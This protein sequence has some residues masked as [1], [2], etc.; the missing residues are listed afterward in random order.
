VAHQDLT[1]K[2]IGLTAEQAFA[3]ATALREQG[4]LSEAERIYRAVLRLD[5]D[6]FESLHALGIICIQ[7]DVPQD[8]LPLIERALLLH[9]NS[10]EAHNN[11]GIALAK[12]GRNEEAVAQYDRAVALAP[13]FAAAHSNAANALAASGR[14]EEAVA[15]FATALGLAPDRSDTHNDLGVALATLGRH[16]EA[17]AH[18]EQAAA[19]QPDF[20]AAHNNLGNALVELDRS[21]EAIAP[22]E[23]ALVIQPDFAQAELNL[24]NALAA[25]HRHDAAVDHYRKAL[26]LEPEL[27]AAHC[28][29]GSSLH[30]SNR[31]QQA[32]MSYERARELDL[33]SAAASHGVGLVLQTLGRLEQSRRALE[34]A[35]EL[36]P[37]MPAY[38]RALA[39]TRVF[40]AGDPQLA[41][42]E[43]LAANLSALP[44]TQQ[45]ELHF[46]LGKA[47]EDLG[48]HE[49]AFRHLLDGNAM[50][51]RREEY[52][53]DATLALWRR[54]ETVFTADLLQRNAGS[55]DPSDAPV[56][57]LGMPRS[58]STLIEQV[59]ASHPRVF[60]AGELR[61]MG[62]AAKAFR[63][64][65][66][67]AYFPEVAASITSEQLRQFGARYVEQIR[68]HAPA[69]DR[70][71]DKMPPNFRFIGLIRLALPNARIIHTQRDPLD[72]CLSCFSRLFGAK[73]FTAELG[74]LGRHYRAYAALMEH[75]RRVLP[76]GAMLEVQ[77]E[78]MV[79][80][81]ENQARRIVTY[82]GLEW[83]DRCLAFHR[84]SRPVR[85]ASVTQVR[86]PIYGTSVGRWRAYEPWLG[87]LFAAL[88]SQ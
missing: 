73:S 56:F 60:G 5:P 55:G 9:P 85:T 26:M 13:D 20:A 83:D 61:Y 29:L 66:V 8:A 23:R 42:M 10:A 35:V 11:R 79:G 22:F 78:D 54:I 84:T 16:A 77:Y 33:R 37:A 44:E 34:R 4:R 31:P 39:E 69:A 3:V 86:R 38:H 75:W 59:L 72:T 67:S 87:P 27:V 2:S 51:R 74:E 48:R 88:N 76:D 6:H 17:V 57:I 32:L 70:V 15:R 43:A 41:A 30:M 36:A 81:F 40:S 58:G 68:S 80:D 45:I 21:K 47:Y 24:A 28:G 65:D 7:R 12:L 64:K 62:D 82:C 71:T 53:E 52:D 49:L 25:L 18:F 19:L 46:A 63:G 14:T 50:K 1:R